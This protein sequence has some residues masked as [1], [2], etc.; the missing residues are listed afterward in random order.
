MIAGPGTPLNAV[1]E[2]C[3]R[4]SDI[5][6]D[7]C[8]ALCMP[9]G[10]RARWWDCVTAETRPRGEIGKDWPCCPRRKMNGWS[11]RRLMIMLMGYWRQ[12]AACDHRVTERDDEK[13]T[14]FHEQREE[15]CVMAH[16]GLKILSCHH[17]HHLAQ[18]STF[19]PRPNPINLVIQNISTPSLI[20]KNNL[21]WL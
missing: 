12:N 19:R 21:Y 9:E 13:F 1:V 8:G 14:P 16:I 17:R 5:L 10:G 15:R 2:C 20:V 6:A 7:F 3:A 4:W 18:E 11:I